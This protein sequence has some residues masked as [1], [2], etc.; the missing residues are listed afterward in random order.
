MHPVLVV[1]WV[2]YL[3]LFL[4]ARYFGS[5]MLFILCAYFSCLDVILGLCSFRLP[6]PLM[7][8]PNIKVFQLLL[9]SVR[10]ANYAYSFIVVLIFLQL[11]S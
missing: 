11:A 7:V 8:P 9:F 5:N 2:A 4:T 10:S 3:H 1:F 6:N